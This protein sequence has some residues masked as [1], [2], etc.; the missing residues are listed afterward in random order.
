M[1]AVRREAGQQLQR[2]REKTPTTEDQ[3]VGK[4]NGKKE[5]TILKTEPTGC[6]HK[7]DWV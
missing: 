2:P 6:K 1:G 3:S 7:R 4:S 5:N